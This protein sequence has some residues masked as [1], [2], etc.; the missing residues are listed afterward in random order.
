MS[1]FLKGLKQLPLT[2]KIGA[3]FG[4]YGWSGKAV[5]FIRSALVAQ[6]ISARAVAAR[7]KRTP[8][9]AAL[10]NCRELG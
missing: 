9:R 1:R 3:V 4:S 8:D 5:S 2:G 6:G 7:A 10:A